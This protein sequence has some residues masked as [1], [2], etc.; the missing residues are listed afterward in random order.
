MVQRRLKLAD[1]I[2]SQS[3]NILLGFWL[4]FREMGLGVSRYPWLLRCWLLLLEMGT[5]GGSW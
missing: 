1:D 5:K 4:L 2:P 3:V